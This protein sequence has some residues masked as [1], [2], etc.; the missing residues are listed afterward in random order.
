MLKILFIS[1]HLNPFEQTRGGD[2]QRTN[3]LLR[4]CAGLGVVDVVV[5]Q[6]DVLSDIPNCNVIYSQ[7]VVSVEQSKKTRWSKWLPFLQF[8]SAEA[9]FK[10]NKCKTT[11]VKTI[12]EK[13]IYDFIVVRYIPKAM[14]C[15]LLDYANKLVVDVDDL[16]E[17]E[18]RIF[19]RDARTISGRIRNSLFS[20]LAKW[21]T[22]QILDK[23]KFSFFANPEQVYK[24]N[25]A[26]LPNIPFYEQFVCKDIDFNHTPKRLFFIGDLNYYPNYMGINYFL[27][28]I[29]K[30]LQQ[31]IDDVEFCIAGK[32]SDLELKGRWETYPNVRIL[33][34]VEDIVAAY[35]NSRVVVVPIFQGAGTNIKLLEAMQMNRA[36]VVSDFATRGFSTIFKDETDYCVARNDKEYTEKIELL[37]TDELK[38]KTIAHNGSIKVKK[39]FSFT[40]FSTIVKQAFKN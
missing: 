26:Y 10:R 23:V 9:L 3:L 21:N 30:P 2:A 37:L 19:A 6:K 13:N 25:A 7:D 29:Y 40:S 32:I 11:I 24:Q 28:Q 22:K 33:G 16:P 34:Y 17:D 39:Y 31:K 1:S 20:Y 36:C 15:G 8:W 12:I 35:T 14:E 18:F 27:E 4:A 5:F 38:N